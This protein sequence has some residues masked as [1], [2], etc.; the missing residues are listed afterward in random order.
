MRHDPHLDSEIDALL[1]PRS[2]IAPATRADV[3]ESAAATTDRI[4]RLIV[5]N[6]LLLERQRR[7]TYLVEA[8]LLISGLVLLA[9]LTR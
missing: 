1:A 9:L 4:E 6:E 7:L 3:R 8:C 2:P 5:L